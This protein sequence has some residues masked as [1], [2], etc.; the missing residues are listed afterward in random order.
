[1]PDTSGIGGQNFAAALMTGLMNGWT[2]RHQLGQAQGRE[3]ELLAQKQARQDALIQQGIDEEDRRYKQGLV[4]QLGVEERSNAEWRE[5]QKI[6]AALRPEAVARAPK[7]MTVKELRL[8]YEGLAEA[9]YLAI[10]D[11]EGLINKKNYSPEEAYR[12]TLGKE[13]ADDFAKN[14]D[15]NALFQDL[16]K[17]PTQ[18]YFSA[19][20]IM[21]TYPGVTGVPDGMYSMA[22]VGAFVGMNSVGS[23]DIFMGEYRS[24]LFNRAAAMINSVLREGGVPEST[25]L[26]KI[27]EDTGGSLLDVGRTLISPFTDPQKKGESS[28]GILKPKGKEDLQRLLDLLNRAT[29]RWTERGK[30][31]RELGR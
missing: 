28:G 18:K 15:I 29:P 12:Y 26:T 5:R 2:K 3:D 8:R 25:G 13:T 7:P 24:D 21:T 11:M 9:N 22:E 14:A 1:M 31:S 6:L 27:L 10:N 4:D 19:E 23:D 16:G 17:D 20:D 30:R